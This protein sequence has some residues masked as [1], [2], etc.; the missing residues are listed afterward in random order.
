MK[1]LLPL[2]CLILGFGL[3]LGSVVAQVEKSSS[4]N[5][6]IQLTLDDVII[7]PVAVEYIEQGL[8]Q[9]EASG[10]V[11]LLIRLDTPGGLLNSTRTIVKRILSA[12]VPV[13]VYVAPPGA[14]AG[15]SRG[16]VANAGRRES[17]ATR[18]EDRPGNLASVLRREELFFDANLEA[19]TRVG[20]EIT[21]FN[22]TPRDEAQAQTASAG[23]SLERATES[24]CDPRT[25]GRK[26]GRS[27][28]RPRA[29]A[30]RSSPHRC[31]NRLA[32]R[33]AL[34]RPA[35]PSRGP[36]G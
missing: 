14:R 11:A 16:G 4:Q 31:R 32:R 2:L 35:H 1:R 36:S 20:L 34:G 5:K 12:K 30:S 15:G 28:D 7:G 9:A 25:S 10:A 3:W 22:L 26:R 6:I 29:T 8:E 13:I 19:L 23:P 27:G 17:T 21:R 18:V 33:H 24:A